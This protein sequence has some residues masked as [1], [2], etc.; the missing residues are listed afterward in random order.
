MQEY[1]RYKRY[2]GKSPLG[3]LGNGYSTNAN[4]YYQV[5]ILKCSESGAIKVNSITIFNKIYC[6][7][8]LARTSFHENSIL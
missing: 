2:H 6:S 7:D 4:S 1:L 5:C 8:E 3:S